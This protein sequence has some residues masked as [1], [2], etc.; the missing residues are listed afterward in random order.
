MA[1]SLDGEISEENIRLLATQPLSEEV[2]SNKEKLVQ[3]GKSIEFYRGLISSY[4][5]TKFLMEKDPC[6]N[7]KTS[8]S[9]M[10]I[11]MALPLLA[12]EYL[13]KKPSIIE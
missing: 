3:G 7:T 11:K 5:Q 4:S 12:R 1:L 9:Y 6:I 13:S 8:M 10:M 2:E